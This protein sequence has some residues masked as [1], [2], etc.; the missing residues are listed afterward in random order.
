VSRLPLL[1]VLML[2]ALPAGVV[3]FLVACIIHGYNMGSSFWNGLVQWTCT[4]LRWR[5]I[6]W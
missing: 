1:I 4:S 3:G 6:K 5:D 2:L